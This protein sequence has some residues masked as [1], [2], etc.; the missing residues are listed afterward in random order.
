MFFLT[1]MNDMQ[2]TVKSDAMA[3][4]DYSTADSPLAL[5][6]ARKPNLHPTEGMTVE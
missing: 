2:T 3:N 5:P 4:V 6:D 1:A